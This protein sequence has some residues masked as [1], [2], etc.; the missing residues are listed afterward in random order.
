MLDLPRRG[1]TDVLFN[2]ACQKLRGSFKGTG[3]KL[4]LES[5]LLDVTSR[6]YA[7]AV[8]FGQAGVFWPFVYVQ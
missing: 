2:A 6:G 5:G 4:H 7:D 8:E 3:I 1:A